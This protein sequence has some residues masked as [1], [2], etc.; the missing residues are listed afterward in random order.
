MPDIFALADG[1][2]LQNGKYTIIRMLAHGG[3]GVTYL[4]HHEMLDIDVCIKEFFPSMWC[5]RDA[6]SYEISVATAGNTDTVARFMD[7]FLKEARSIARLHHEGIIKI[8]DVFREN[9]TAYYVMDYIDGCS[10]QDLVK[11]NGPLPLDVALGYIRQAAEALGYLHANHMNHLDVKPANMMVDAKG[12]LTLI[13]FG[14]A[15]HYGEDGHQTT[16]TP[17]CISRGYSPIEQYKDGGVSQFSPVADIYPL[18]A[19]LYYLLTGETPP[20][21]TELTFGEITIPSSIP[22]HVASAIRNAMRPNPADRTPSIPAFLSALTDPSATQPA[23][24]P[25]PT[26]TPTPSP[27]P[28]PNPTPSPAPNPTPVNPTPAPDPKP[29]PTRKPAIIR[30][31]TIALIIIAIAIAAYAAIS[32]FNS[33]PEDN[34][35]TKIYGHKEGATGDLLTEKKGKYRYFTP[36]EWSEVPDQSSY[37]KLGVIVNDGSCSPFYIALYDKANGEKMTWDEAVSRYGEDILP[38]EEQ[39]FAMLNNRETINASMKA[40]AGNIM[41]GNEDWGH[42]ISYWG[43]EKNSSFAW[44]VCMGNGNVACN[45]TETVRVRAVAP[46][47]VAS[48]M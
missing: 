23:P 18:G 41:D 24:E 17:L 30:F 11:K 28:T 20:E 10:L 25:Q 1:Q 40:F 26:P 4:A 12:R 47:P 8:Q 19:T 38:S 9:G 14:V 33:N 44:F 42:F 35:E 27:S 2:T 48:A 13:D 15:K 29:T 7:K 16:T 5:N 36:N 43:K 31:W 6:F 22:S 46:L 37:T 34:T 3:F 39:C 32:H 45:K 21:A